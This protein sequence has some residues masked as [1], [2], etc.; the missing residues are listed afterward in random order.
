[1]KR[2]FIVSTKRRIA[3]PTHPR[4]LGGV[5][6][7]AGLMSSMMSFTPVSTRAEAQAAPSG[8]LTWGITSIDSSL[9]PGLLYALDPNVV[10]AAE[11]NSLVQYGP[12]G[13]LEPEL[14]SSWKQTSPTTIVYNLVHDAR[15]W[16]GD[17]VTPRDVAF[18]VNRIFNPTLANPTPFP[19]HKSHSLLNPVPSL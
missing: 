18:S 11:C 1:M 15:F 13:Q 6:A 14:A 17:P 10:S 2:K 8:T 9:D 4:R 12:Q 5:A 19:S 16:D 3:V 7:L